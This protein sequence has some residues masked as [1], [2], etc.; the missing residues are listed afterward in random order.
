MSVTLC[1]QGPGSSCMRDFFCLR[2]TELNFPGRKQREISGLRRAWAK[3][4]HADSYGSSLRLALLQKQ[5]QGFVA[6]IGRNIGRL[7][8]PVD[9]E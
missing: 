2:D 8:R 4:E 9:E 3:S 6:A 5:I 1:R 7:K